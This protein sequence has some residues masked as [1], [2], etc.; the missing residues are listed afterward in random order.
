MEE[1]FEIR[2]RVSDPQGYPIIV[3]GP[4]GNDEQKAYRV[5]ESKYYNSDNE[6]IEIL[7]SDSRI[8]SWINSYGLDKAEINTLKSIIAQIGSR[9]EIES[10]TSGA[11]STKFVSL[12]SRYRYLKGMLTDLENEYAKNNK[13]SRIGISR[14]PTIA[15]GYV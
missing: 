6:L 9:I 12:S 14:Q 11:E 4:I 15:G 10:D 13:S 8:Q 5:S 3:D 1:L 2:L 7:V